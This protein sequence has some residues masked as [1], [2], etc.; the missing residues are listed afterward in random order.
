MTAQMSK[1]KSIC[2]LIENKLQEEQQQSS[3]EA[4]GAGDAH[5]LGEVGEVWWEGSRDWDG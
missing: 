4:L 1:E 3:E 2:Y 5:P